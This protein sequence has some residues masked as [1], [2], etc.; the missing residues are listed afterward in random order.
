LAVFD[1]EGVEGLTALSET[2]QLAIW[3]EQIGELI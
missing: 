2:F 3:A 1:A